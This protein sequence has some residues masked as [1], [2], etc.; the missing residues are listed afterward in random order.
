MMKET[1][2]YQAQN[3]TLF[4]LNIVTAKGKEIFSSNSALS[5][6]SRSS[7]F[8]KELLN[9]FNTLFYKNITP[10][11]FC[12]AISNIGISNID[13]ERL[14][15]CA[16]LY[17]SYVEIMQENSYKIP[18]P[19]TYPDIK[20]MSEK[21]EINTCLEILKQVF[22]QKTKPDIVSKKNDFVSYLEFSDIQSESRF[23]ISKIK[24]FV[25][26]KKASYKDIAVFADKSEARQKFLDMMK[27]SQIPVES[28]IY[29]ENYENLKH[30]LNVYR[31]I[32]DICLQLKLDSFSSEAF[33]TLHETSAAHGVSRSQ[34]EICLEKLDELIKNLL[35]ETLPDGYTTDRL[36][37]KKENSQ[38]SLIETLY[39]SWGSLSEEET[40][41]I[42]EEFGLVKNFYAHYGK[43]DFASACECV[44][45]KYLKYFENITEIAAGKIKSLKELQTLYSDVLKITPD[46]DAFREIL[47]WLPKDEE[48]G[49]DALKL[50]S[51]SANLKPDE[52]FKAV[53]I[54]GLTENNFPGTNASYPFISL[55]ANELLNKE[56][57]KLDPEFEGFLK[58][59]DMFFEQKYNS[60][61]SIISHAAEH[62]IFTSHAYEA[63]KS[64]LPS[65]FFKALSQND[66]LNFKKISD[67]EL[68]E[69]KTGDIQHLQ[70]QKPAEEK[71][72][73][74]ND[75]LRLNP[76]SISTFQQCPRK[77]FYKN[78]LNLKEKST[79]SASYGSIVHAV[80]EVLNRR[81]CSTGMYNK[82]T[83][84]SLAEVLF[85]S[86]NNEENA[87][88]AGFKQTDADL[89][90]AADELSLKEMKENFKNAL[91][92]YEMMGYFDN[93]FE[94]AVC[95]T[96]FSFTVEELPNVIFDGRI[97]AILSETDG[98]CVVV[99]Y[100]TGKDKINTLEY[101]VSEYGVNFKTKTG[102]DPS[103]I[104][105][106]Q[107]IYDYQIPLYYLAC[108][109]SE[110]LKEY[111]NSVKKLGLVYIRPKSKYDGCKKDFVSAEKLE[112]Y[113]DKILQNLKETVIDKIVNEKEFKGTKNWNCDSCSF[114][115]LCDG[116]E[117]DE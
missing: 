6:L 44:I 56:L 70:Q 20:H 63:K 26:A 86:K 8:F 91:N 116:G 12:A 89:V 10:E 24:E 22:E 1:E 65:V 102:K 109:N 13:K 103:N 32:S 108:K 62:I 77:Y 25:E 7:V 110:D 115:F 30:K 67:E 16:K 105:T 34:K 97:D 64:A 73:K 90:K 88:K 106:L 107:N 111:K 11:K 2:K 113:K 98:N 58:T 38:K 37:S 5:C 74:D 43:T 57:Q 76:S 83:A 31:Q 29:N 9:T 45:R 49:K 100:K 61:C 39:S 50:A 72:V 101:A 96:S 85:E 66:K 104:E 18:A 17:S 92:D 75:K 52:K 71:I 87:L 84:L 35:D 94:K 23:V 51:V 81:F 69:E 114:K 27:N 68:P 3:H 48:K 4:A 95:E 42:S 99:D 54:C 15:L 82:T 79:F 40:K 60:F 93:V 55:Q 59:D 33:K 47:E 19:S 80:F 41:V 46:F 36:I 21:T 28:S 117:D 78:L 53:F 112:Q 14:E